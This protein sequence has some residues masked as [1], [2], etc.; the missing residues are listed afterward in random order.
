VAFV[1]GFVGEDFQELVIHAPPAF[2][3]IV[4]LMVFRS[5]GSGAES[6]ECLTLLVIR[7]SLPVAVPG[8]ELH[9][10][11]PEIVVAAVKGLAFLIEGERLVSDLLEPD[12]AGARLGAC[13]DAF[14]CLLKNEN[15][16]L[17]A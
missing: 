8:V 9:K 6:G 3:P 10:S 16:S 14:T 5:G 11:I 17:H 4:G 13:D 2:F 15:G 12:F 7:F 1:A